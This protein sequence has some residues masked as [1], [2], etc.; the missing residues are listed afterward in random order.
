MNLILHLV[1]LWLKICKEDS[2]RKEEFNSKATEE[3]SENKID[4]LECVY[5]IIKEY[6]KIMNDLQH[7]PKF[8][9]LS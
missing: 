1:E 3:M 5:Q 2:F 7:N 9:K 6:D 4:V 8:L